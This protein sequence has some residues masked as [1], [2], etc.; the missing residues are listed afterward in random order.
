MSLT[1]GMTVVPDS[2]HAVLIVMAFWQHVDCLCTYLVRLAI[3]TLDE[4]RFRIK[5]L[6]A[7]DGT[8]RIAFA[9]S[10]NIATGSTS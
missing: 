8:S 10:S 3:R 1:G 9:P 7:R 2:S 6:Y 5:L 4:A